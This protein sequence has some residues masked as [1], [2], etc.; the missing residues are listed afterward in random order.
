MCLDSICVESYWA[1]HWIVAITTISVSLPFQQLSSIHDFKEFKKNY[2]YF[3]FFRTEGYKFIINKK[4]FIADD[5]NLRI[6]GVKIGTVENDFSMMT[7][8]MNKHVWKKLCG[9]V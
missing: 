2:F 6:F 8:D 1:N 9:W 4:K 5:L 7:I 3:K